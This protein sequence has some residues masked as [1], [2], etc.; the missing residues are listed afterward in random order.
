MLYGPVFRTL[1]PSASHR[2]RGV[3]DPRRVPAYTRRTL[4]RTLSSVAATVAV[5]GAFWAG[6][7]LTHHDVASADADPVLT[8]VRQELLHAYYRPV[9]AN[10]LNAPSV[11]AMLSALHDPYTDYLD[12]TRFRLLS[13]ETHSSYPGIGVSIL[14]TNA[15][16]EVVATKSGPA[17]NAGI[18]RGDV[19]TA[20]NG[21]KAAGITLNFAVSRILGAAG[22]TIALDVRRD[23]SSL[24]FNIVRGTIAAPTVQTRLMQDA[25]LRIGYVRLEEFRLGATPLVGRALRR[26]ERQNAAGI[27]L[28][29]RG[30]PGGV[31]DQAVGVSSLF[32]DRGV[33]VTLVGVHSGRNVYSAHGGGMHLPLVVLVDGRSASAA[34]IVAAALQDNRRAVIVGENTFGKALVQSIRPLGNGAALRLTTAHYITPSGADIS[35]R[36]VTPDLRA[37]DDPATQQDEALQAA[38]HLFLR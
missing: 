1:C 16:L 33:I 36:G 32:L 15:G 9:P 3:Y 2:Q 10:V 35:L 28:D 27:V 19:I 12:A 18:R 11:S 25:K 37:V 34:E 20:V 17:E 31:F 13:R 7:A 4:R 24:H 22:T 26:L 8:A 23:T 6:L 38:L 21:E 29:L 30:N 5:V 14:P